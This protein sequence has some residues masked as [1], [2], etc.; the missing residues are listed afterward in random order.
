[1]PS[2]VNDACVHGPSIDSAVIQPSKTCRYR[3]LP[4]PPCSSSAL[5]LITRRK[6]LSSGTGR[7]T[8]APSIGTRI[9]GTWLTMTCGGG[10][11]TGTVCALT[12]PAASEA[13][14]RSSEIVRAR[15]ARLACSAAV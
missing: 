13:S 7:H 10:L 4:T 8:G 14:S 9:A 2:G 15:D 6:R 3:R 5:V 11:C 12:W 1:M